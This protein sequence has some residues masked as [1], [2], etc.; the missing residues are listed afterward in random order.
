ML[1]YCAL[2]GNEQAD[3]L[4][5]RGAS[6]LQHRNTTISYWT[7]KPLLKR[8]FRSNILRDLQTCTTLKSWRMISP[9][10]ISDSPRR[11][12]KTAFRLSTGHDFLAAHLHCIGISSDPIRTLCDSGEEMDRDHLLRCGLTEESRY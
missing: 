5:K 1:G 3:F 2:W 8:L 12:A 7:I 6:L 9:S 11:N 10:L 4:A